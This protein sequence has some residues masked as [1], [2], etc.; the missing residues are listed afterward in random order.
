MMAWP[1][2]ACG[3]ALVLIG[4]V[5]YSTADPNPDTG[6]VSMTA[7]IP[8][9]VGGLLMLIGALAFNDRR[10]KHVMHLA[11]MVGLFGLVGGFMPLMRQY[12]AT[13]TVDPLKPSAVSG[14]LM[15]VVCAV[16]VWLCVNSFL[17]ARRARKMNRGEGML[18]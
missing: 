5:G 9:F 14:E 2:I 3:M 6:K 15:I 4:V 8:A 10:R 1:T 16:F 7:L 11:A 12:N 18:G 17:A 13:G